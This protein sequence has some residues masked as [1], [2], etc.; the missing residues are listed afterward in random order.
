LPAKANLS[1][2]YASTPCLL[3]I[4]SKDITVR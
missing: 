3:A 4:L 2:S 1:A